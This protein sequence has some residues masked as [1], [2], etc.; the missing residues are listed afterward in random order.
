MNRPSFTDLAYL[1]H[2]TMRLINT[3]TFRFEFFAGD[4]PPYAILSHTWGDEEVIFQDLQAG[5]EAASARKGFNKIRRC[6]EQAVNDG[7]EWAWVDTCCIDKTS[8]AE[9]SEA[10]NSMYQ[11]YKLSAICYV[12]M[13]DV[14]ATPNTPVT[15]LAA[16][17]APPPPA[18]TRRNLGYDFPRSRWFK[19]GWTLQELIAPRRLEFYDMHWK[20]IG[21]K[22]SLAPELK[23]ITGIRAEV[24]AGGPMTRCCMAERMSWAAN[25]ETTK[26]E[27]RAYSLLG[28][29]DVN[30]P[31][32]YG[33][34]NRAFLRLQEEIIRRHEDLS[35]L[36][37]NMPSM[38]AVDD[39][40][41]APEPNGFTTVLATYNPPV[42]RD[43]MSP[44]RVHQGITW[45]NVR[46]VASIGLEAQSITSRGILVTLYVDTPA[47]HNVHHTT[48]DVLA[49]TNLVAEF[50][51][52]HELPIRLCILMRS[53]F[54]SIGRVSDFPDYMTLERPRS[55][56]HLGMICVPE[57]AVKSFV[58]KKFYLPTHVEAPSSSTEWIVRQSW[59]IQGFQGASLRDTAAYQGDQNVLTFRLQ[60]ATGVALERHQP[61]QLKWVEMRPGLYS[62]FLPVE[63]GAN[64]TV[65]EALFFCSRHRRNPGGRSIVDRFVAYFIATPEEQRDVL[66][67]GCSLLE[68]SPELSQNGLAAQAVRDVKTRK[69]S[70][71]FPFSDRS[72]LHLQDGTVVTAAVKQ[73]VGSVAGTRSFVNVSLSVSFTEGV[74]LP[75][76]I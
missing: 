46:R 7:Y 8:S 76:T 22:S 71:E 74:P 50:D 73:Y 20:E 57:Y 11:W 45:E 52:P 3:T 23:R 2:P 65:R 39:S 59:S 25:R 62:F 36:A 37:W 4:V 70:T 44:E 41:L 10:I 53:R 17:L 14:E 63:D 13:E 67:C 33:E 18:S 61:T 1:R 6:C 58:P 19:R 34:G 66:V 42:I 15:A 40:V 72:H 75:G 27:D 31:L 54:S 38:D 26:I 30:M 51:G 43:R 5:P 48:H 29:F 49:W 32:L 55:S 24:L 21:T 9:L 60:P 16:L 69:S 68:W 12:Y 56:R 28:I 64:S 35:L 47:S